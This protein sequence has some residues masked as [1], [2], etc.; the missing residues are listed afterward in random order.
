MAPNVNTVLKTFEEQLPERVP[1][2][3][4]VLTV[5]GG[6][7]DHDGDVV[8]AG[9]VVATTLQQSSQHYGL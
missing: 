8:S 1:P 9:G 4:D 3:R 6:T 2:S 7:V 5:L